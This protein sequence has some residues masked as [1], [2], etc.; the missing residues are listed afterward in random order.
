[1]PYLA[2]EFVEGQALTAWC[3]THRYSLRE[4]LKLFLQVL[5]A[6]QYAHSHQVFTV[7]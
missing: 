7:I 5:D 2:L 1:V 6:V 4:R 3:D